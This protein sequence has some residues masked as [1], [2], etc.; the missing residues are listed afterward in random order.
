MYYFFGGVTGLDDPITTT[1][2]SE[3]SATVTVSPAWLASTL[4]KSP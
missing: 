2:G 4:V 3:H 1:H